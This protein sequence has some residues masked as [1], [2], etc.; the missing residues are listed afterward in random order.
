MAALPYVPS[1]KED[2]VMND[3]FEKTYQRLFQADPP[4]RTI[5]GVSQADVLSEGRGFMGGFDYTMQLQVGC[6]A[7]C[8]FCYVSCGPMLAPIAVRGEKGRNWG[9]EVRHKEDAV[10]KFAKH[11]TRGALADTTVYWSGVTDPYAAPRVVTRGVWEALLG[12]PAELR[13]RRVAVQTRFRPDRDSAL[14]ARYE[15]DTRPSDGGPAVVFSCSLGTDRDDLIRAWER[16]TP[17]FE[18][19]MR[20]IGKLRQEGLFVVATLSPFGLWLD[21]QGTLRRL[22]ELGV[23]YVTV[24]FF[25]Q[26]TSSA[27]TPRN[28]QKL[29]QDEYP[30]VL[31]PS[32]QAER[33]G[34]MQDVLGA[35]RVLVGKAGFES[36]T[37]PHTVGAS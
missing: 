19:R 15:Q 10:C 28:F 18:Q 31:D 37:C 8:Q 14:I 17:T 21:L 24:L 32:W 11:L 13:P 9:F 3:S 26:G 27:N 7:G 29:L 30:Q 33:L 22:K 5:V 12:A 23:A 4:P 34:E 35:K 6:P 2:Y 20:C 25:K 36:L 16:A 1:K